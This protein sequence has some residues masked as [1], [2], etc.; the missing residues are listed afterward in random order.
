MLRWKYVKFLMSI[1][2]WQVNSSSSFASFFA[3]MT[4]NSYVNF[5]LI[6]FLLWMK[7]SHQ[8]PNFE[9]FKISGNS[10]SNSSGEFWKHKSF[11]H[12][13]M[14]QYSVPTN[15]TPLYI[16]SSDIIYFGQKHPIKVK[17]FE[18]F[19]CSVQNSS[20]SSCHFWTDKSVAL[21]FLHHSSLSWHITPC[22][23]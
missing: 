17:I 22:K 15:I 8:S 3:V 9:T 10:F 7:E 14:H 2:K 6:H 16:F 11:F 12:K 21:Q 19:E 5:K 23:L 13:I 18:I 1:W 4:H 20:K